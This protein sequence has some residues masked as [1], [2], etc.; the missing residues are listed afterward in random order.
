MNLLESPRRGLGTA[1]EIPGQLHPLS[2]A[3]C[4][5]DANLSP[6]IPKLSTQRI[7]KRWQH[8]VE[9]LSHKV[10][11]VIC[12]AVI[13]TGYVEKKKNHFGKSF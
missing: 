6:I 7:H 12:Y 4:M 2:V 9:I 5:G 11:G 13:L 1:R 10:L 3:Y 8:F